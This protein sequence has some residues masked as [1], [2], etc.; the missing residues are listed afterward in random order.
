MVGISGQTAGYL[1]SAA[2]SGGSGGGSGG[3]SFNFNV[4]G[5]GGGSTAT[6]SSPARGVPFNPAAIYPAYLQAYS[7]TFG[8]GMPIYDSTAGM[9]PEQ[10][11][12]KAIA[13]AG[14]ASGASDVALIA[15][16]LTKLFSKKYPSA[17]NKAIA[18]GEKTSF[19][20]DTAPV[21]TPSISA[22]E[23]PRNAPTKSSTSYEPGSRGYETGFGQVIPGANAPSGALSSTASS[24]EPNAT[25]MNVVSNLLAHIFGSSG[26]SAT[27][28]EPGSR[29]YDTGSGESIPGVNTGYSGFG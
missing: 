9:T 19:G 18:S 17:V 24:Y 7:Q 27:S 12:A 22:P 29:G 23:T 3:G 1:A 10:K 13:D 5:G 16:L 21:A 15:L 11:R 25:M 2:S 8:G 28:Y 26:G 6:K 20:F 14:M 4:G